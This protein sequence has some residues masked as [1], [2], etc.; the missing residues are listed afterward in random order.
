MRIEQLLSVRYHVALS[1]DGFAVTRYA[2]KRYSYVGMNKDAA[3]DC[4]AAMV[5]KYTRIRFGIGGTD[6]TGVARSLV[7]MADIE[8]SNTGADAYSVSVNVN[9]TDARW[10]G[11]IPADPASLFEVENARDYDE[12]PDLIAYERL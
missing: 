3:K 1:G 9:E 2:S 10:S 8:M 12:G 6:G 7:C 4:R 5:A 11:S